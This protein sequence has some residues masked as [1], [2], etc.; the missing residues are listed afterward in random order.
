M[1]T[2]WFTLLST[3]RNHILLKK[4]QVGLIDTT[5]RSGRVVVASSFLMDSCRTF[6]HF[7]PLFEC[8]DSVA[9]DINTTHLFVL[10][11]IAYYSLDLISFHNWTCTPVLSTHCNAISISC[12]LRSLALVVSRPITKYTYPSRQKIHPFHL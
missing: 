8:R 1:G 5:R 4:S 2:S 7:A 3:C 10:Q 6:R 11:Q 9:H 12:S